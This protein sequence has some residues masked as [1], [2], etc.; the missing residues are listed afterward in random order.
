MAHEVVGS[1]QVIENTTKYISS[2]KSSIPHFDVI[3]F[4]KEINDTSK[5]TNEILKKILTWAKT[6][7]EEI[8]LVNTSVDVTQVLKVIY[9]KL[10]AQAKDKNIELIDN[11]PEN[12]TLM[13]DVNAFTLIIHSLIE[14][15]VKHN[16]NSTIRVGISTDAQFDIEIKNNND[17]GT[18]DVDY[19][20]GFFASANNELTSNTL[21]SGLGFWII[22]DLL[23]KSGGKIH[24]VR[25]SDKSHVTR[26]K[27]NEMD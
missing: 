6:Q 24:F 27:I 9:Q 15:Q 25:S 5:T 11:L 22:K 8:K 7:N 10:L 23:K 1:I 14:N 13:T 19:V 3:D 2:N 17:G 4:I 18:L 12:F 16:D 20:N 21:A 26:I